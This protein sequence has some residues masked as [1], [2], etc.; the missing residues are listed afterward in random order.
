VDRLLESQGVAEG[1][2]GGE[3]DQA[4]LEAQLGGPAQ[5]RRALARR[6]ALRDAA[7]AER[8]LVER[9]EANTA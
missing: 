8:A 3:A 9:T 4:Q 1:G 2:Q 7:A 6:A 5:L